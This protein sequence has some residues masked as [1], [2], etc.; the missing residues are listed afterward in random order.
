MQ[1]CYS[2]ARTIPNY[3]TTDMHNYSGSIRKWIDTI[4]ICFR[5]VNGILF[6]LE[7]VTWGGNRM[8]ERSTQIYIYLTLQHHNYWNISSPC[9]VSQFSPIRG[10]LHEHEN[11]CLLSS[12]SEEPPLPVMQ[13]RTVGLWQL[14]MHD[15]TCKG[16][17][18]EK[19]EIKCQLRRKYKLPQFSDC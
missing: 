10:T 17:E 16:F 13:P 12:A 6:L 3:G 4:R 19:R 2:R 9:L 8:T 11:A 18:L 5:N 15:H 1:Q 7:R 14:C